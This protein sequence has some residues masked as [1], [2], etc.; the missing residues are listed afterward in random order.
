MQHDPPALAHEER[1]GSAHRNDHPAAL[2]QR[3][4][5]L[6]ECL[7]DFLKLACRDHEPEAWGRTVALLT[8]VTGD[9]GEVAVRVTVDKLLD[10]LR[11]LRRSLASTPADAED[12]ES[13]LKNVMRFVGED[14][15]K[16]A[17]PQCLQGDWYARIQK[18]LADALA[19][20]RSGRDW[21]EVLDEVEGVDSV[22]I[23]TTH[24]SKGLEYHTV[25]FVGLED[26]AHF[27]LRSKTA[28]GEVSRFP[29]PDRPPRC[30]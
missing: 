13:V 3:T 8:E 19:A 30:A 9:S 28:A 18:D 24:K 17:N 5:P 25:I 4:E 14:D 26:G 12:V 2:D 11:K 29:L 16:S 22:P 10:Y 6:S 15:F 7:L 20:A 21:S 27:S 23:M 1:P